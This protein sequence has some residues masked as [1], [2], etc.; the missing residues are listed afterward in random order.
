MPFDQIHKRLLALQP[1][2]LDKIN[3]LLEAF[4]LKRLNE[5]TPGVSFSKPKV[6]WE[7]EQYVQLAIY[8]VYELGE[9]ATEAWN[10]LHPATSFILTRALIENVAVLV[11]LTSQI[12][13]LTAEGKLTK[14]HNLVV[15]RLLGGKLE[16][17]PHELKITNVLTLIDKTDKQFPDYMVRQLYDFLSE[18]A[19]PNSLGM[20]RLYGHL[21]P[22]TQIF[23]LDPA[24]AMTANNFTVLTQSLA[25]ILSIF[26]NIILKLESLYPQ[27]SKLD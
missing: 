7:I 6:I 10:S 21:E 11:D 12:E 22:S 18:F 23:R 20:H 26:G 24:N 2:N 4:S 3:N 5:I 25:R 27:I 15:N 13:S 16:R 9:G 17:Y 19:H 1:E 14:I 8:R